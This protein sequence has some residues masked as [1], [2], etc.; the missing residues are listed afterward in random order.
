MNIKEHIE[1]GHYP[2]DDKG[3]PVVRS[4]AGGTLTVASIDKPGPYPIVGW[5]RSGALASYAA[6]SLDLCQPPPRKMKVTRW[7]ALN[8]MGGGAI[9]WHTHEAATKSANAGHGPIVELTG[10]Y[11]VPWL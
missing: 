4:S 9:A 3:R 1:A 10:E 7:V 8:D 11:E 5:Y 6:D 2:V